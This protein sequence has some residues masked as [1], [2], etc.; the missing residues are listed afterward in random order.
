MAVG[1]QNCRRSS[2]QQNA[3]A[4]DAL[5]DVKKTVGDGKPEKLPF[6]PEHLG[7]CA[8]GELDLKARTK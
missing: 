6:R 2:G 8:T 5:A 7:Q 1:K 4:Q 3:C